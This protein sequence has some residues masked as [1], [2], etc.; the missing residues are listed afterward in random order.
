MF[1]DKSVVGNGKQRRNGTVPFLYYISVA[2]K[3]ED[4]ICCG[5]IGIF[6]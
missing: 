2:F 5:V 3:V 6:H 1:S 4:L